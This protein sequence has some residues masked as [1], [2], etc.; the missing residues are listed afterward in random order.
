MRCWSTIICYVFKVINPDN[1]ENF[2]F[3]DNY[4]I[5]KLF[6]TFLDLQKTYKEV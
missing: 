3:S 2:F 5:L 6:D 1:K 4:I